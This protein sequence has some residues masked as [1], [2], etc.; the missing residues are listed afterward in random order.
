MNN[1][2]IEEKP[3]FEIPDYVYITPI[4]AFLPATIL[5]LIG[6]IYFYKTGKIILL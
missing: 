4:L 3:L 2:S 5:L 6:G 1:E